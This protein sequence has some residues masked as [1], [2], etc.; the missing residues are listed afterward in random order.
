MPATVADKSVYSGETLSWEF[1]FRTEPSPAGS[2][3]DLSAWTFTAQWRSERDAENALDFAVDQ[4]NKATGVII[5]TMTSEQTEAMA[6]GGYF[7][8]DGYNGTDL[9]T[10]LQGRSLWTQGITRA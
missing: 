4:T 5:L 1:R 2:P 3:S 8:L 10:F 6:G 9:V 7:D